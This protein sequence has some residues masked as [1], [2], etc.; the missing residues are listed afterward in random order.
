MKVGRWRNAGLAG[1]LVSALALASCTG[2]ETAEPPTGVPPTG[3]PS[4]DGGG[5]DDP[6]EDGEATDTGPNFTFSIGETYRASG[7]AS[8]DRIAF[9][10]SFFEGVLAPLQALPALLPDTVSVVYDECGQANA[11]HDGA[12]STITLCHELTEYAY[13]LFGDGTR[14]QDGTLLDRLVFSALGFTLYH[15]VGHALDYQRDV[16]IA[17]NIESAMDSIATVIA[18]ETDNA[19]YAIAGAALFY[20]TPPSLGAR[21]GGGLDRGG[22]IACW[23]A[24]GDLVAAQLVRDTRIPGAEGQEGSA[25]PYTLAGRDCATEYAGQLDTVLDWVPNLARLQGLS[26]PPLPDGANTFALE[27]GARW[28]EGAG[29][30]PVTRQSIAA[31]FEEALGPLRDAFGALSAPVRVLYERCG[32]PGSRY[33]SANRTIVVCEELLASVYE[34]HVDGETLTSQEQALEVLH[35]YNS[36]AYFVYHAAGHFLHEAGAMPADVEVESAADALAAV[37]LAE[38]G[39]GFDAFEAGLLVFFQTDTQATLHGEAGRRPTDLI[40]WAIGGDAAL[41]AQPILADTV[42]EYTQGDRDCI[43]EYLSVRDAVRGW[44]SSPTFR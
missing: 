38:A 41:R 30:D 2:A 20:D 25:D 21:H 8:A 39:R 40:C 34:F 16:P 36:T 31:A 1:A 28:L 6:R 13:E 42:A 22:D 7:G 27:F 15:E 11:F 32:A 3:L 18:V 19:L 35:A 29:A 23:T 26:S 9:L 14:E 37:L 33:D 17:G 43:A 24:G 12:V 10:E 5:S 44:L 4:S